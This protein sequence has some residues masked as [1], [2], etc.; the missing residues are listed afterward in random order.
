[1]LS[2]G[3]KLSIFHA[4]FGLKCVGCFFAFQAPF[5]SSVPELFTHGAPATPPYPR[6]C[7]HAQQ[8]SAA[9]G[10]TPSTILLSSFIPDG[11][12]CLPVMDGFSGFWKLGPHLPLVRVWVWGLGVAQVHMAAYQT[13]YSPDRLLSCCSGICTFPILPSPDVDCHGFQRVWSYL[14]FQGG[15]DLPSRWEAFTVL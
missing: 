14:C 10:A 11:L 3:F 9:V 6:P 1:M 5:P 7:P 15:P 4:S 12:L 2:S 8:M 13:M